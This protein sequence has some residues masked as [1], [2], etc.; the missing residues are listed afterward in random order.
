MCV[1]MFA[2]G[3]S[4]STHCPLG[5][6]RVEAGSGKA[7]KGLQLCLGESKGGNYNRRAAEKQESSQAYLETPPCQPPHAAVPKGSCGENDGATCAITVVAPSAR[8]FFVFFLK[9]FLRPYLL[10]CQG[11]VSPAA[12]LS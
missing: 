2:V 5:G 3:A 8:F 10:F 7:F 4:F 12:P 9:L 1:H 6:H 11:F